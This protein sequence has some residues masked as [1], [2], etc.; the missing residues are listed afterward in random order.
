MTPDVEAYAGSLWGVLTVRTYGKLN[1]R[2]LAAVMEEWKAMAEYSGVKYITRPAIGNQSSVFVEITI[3]ANRKSLYLI[4]PY[5][6]IIRH[7]V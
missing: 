2:E 1:D 3:P 6:E 5:N 7:L 4:N